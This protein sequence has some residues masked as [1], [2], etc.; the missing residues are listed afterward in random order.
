[1]TTDQPRPCLHFVGFTDTAQFHRA[2]RIWGQPDFIHRFWDRRA[3]N[4]IM[5][6]DLVIFAT[7]TEDDPLRTWSFDDSSFL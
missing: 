7:G 3:T 6:G 4:E 5:P 2:L 1:M